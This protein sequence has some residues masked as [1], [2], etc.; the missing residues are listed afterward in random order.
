MLGRMES[1][2][3]ARAAVHAAL[4][5]PVRLGIVEDL[6]CSDRSPS[7][8]ARRFGL[9]G[10]L[11]AHHLVVLEDA[12][13]I[14]RVSSSGDGRRRYVQLRSGRLEDLLARS[15]SGAGPVLFVCTQNSARSQLAAA[16]W[17][18]RTGETADSAGT[19][20][21]GRVHPKAVAAA[22]R[23]GIDL[24]DRTPRPLSQVD[25]D[26]VL[27]VTVC[28]RAHEHLGVDAGWH[29]SIPDPVAVGTSRAFDR[30]VAELG[31]RIRAACG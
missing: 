20:P 18:E 26:G 22:A 31:E 4:G 1:G 21:A 9:P 11:L 13:L 10:N 5:D 28:D 16:L 8:L 12:G 19:E 3:E 27:V 6:A 29:W 14:R 15:R 23:V 7:E 24:S 30:T 17:A 2:V 25:P